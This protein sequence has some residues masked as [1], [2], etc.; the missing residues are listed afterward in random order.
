MY[1]TRF[2][3]RTVPGVLFLSRAAARVSSFLGDVVVRARWLRQ[4]CD[5]SKAV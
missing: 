4:D 3:V 5:L 2:N 1:K